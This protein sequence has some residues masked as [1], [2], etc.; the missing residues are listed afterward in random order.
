MLA[1]RLTTMLPAMSLA[2][3][4]ETT[5]IHGVLS[6]TW[7]PPHGTWASRRS[8]RLRTRRASTQQKGHRPARRIEVTVSVTSARP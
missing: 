8:S 5:Y 1:R 2:E 3:A 6:G 7:Y 4:L